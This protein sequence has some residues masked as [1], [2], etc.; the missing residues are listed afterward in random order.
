[1][2]KTEWR[3]S[4]A[5]AGRLLLA[6]VFVFSQT[7]W[8]G[9]NQQIKDK[10]DSLQKAAA[11]QPGAKQPVAAAAKAP[12]GPAQAEESESSAAE[13]KASGDGRHE[14]IKVHGHWTIEVRNPDGTL[15]THREFEN[16]YQP[17]YNTL[18]G[19]LSHVY[20]QGSWA[21]ELNGSACNSSAAYCDITEPGSGVPATSKNLMVTPPNS[22]GAPLVLSG[23][24]QMTVGL[25]IV[26]VYTF[27]GQCVTASISSVTACASSVPPVNNTQNGQ[28]MA[29]FTMKDLS[30]NPIPT[31]AGQTVQVTV[32]ISFS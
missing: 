6:F 11:Q 28:F 3:K 7:V 9:Q 26:S 13:E 20:T 30:S 14:G 22:G 25:Q 24:I 18:T 19:I 4:A 27:L 15:A 5:T 16:A 2:N 1:M 12:S 23:S 8:A 17:A 31:S 32:S 10:A 29:T 21:I